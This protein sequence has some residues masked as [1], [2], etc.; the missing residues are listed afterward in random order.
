MRDNTRDR[1]F[2][3]QGNQIKEIMYTDKMERKRKEDFIKSLST[4]WWS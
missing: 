4:E 3:K 1:L 2:V